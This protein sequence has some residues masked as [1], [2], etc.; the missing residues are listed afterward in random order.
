MYH[1]ISVLVPALVRV[2]EYLFTSTSTS[3]STITL[4]LT[5][6]SKVRVPEIQYS[7]TVSTRT[8]YEYPN[9]GHM[10]SKVWDEITY[11]FSNFNGWSLV[12][13]QF[14]N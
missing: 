1:E 3:T 2:H 12:T 11:Q 14:R 7:S 8:E 5:S 9:P 10:L 13:S 6:M 4:E